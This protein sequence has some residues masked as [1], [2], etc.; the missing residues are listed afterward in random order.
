MRL[1]GKVA[2]VPGAQGIGV[3]Y[4]RALRRCST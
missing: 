2:V 4:A 3:A 1:E